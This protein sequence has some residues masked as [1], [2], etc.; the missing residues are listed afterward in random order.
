MTSYEIVRNLILLG[1]VVINIFKIGL[2]NTPLTSISL[3]NNNNNISLILEYNLSIYIII[4][5]LGHSSRYLATIP[6]PSLAILNK[7]IWGTYFVVRYLVVS[8]PIIS[9]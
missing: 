1:I 5:L 9:Q 7:I 2:G 8:L 4:S 3:A 6:R